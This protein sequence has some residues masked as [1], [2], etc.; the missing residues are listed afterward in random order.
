MLAKSQRNSYHPN[1]VAYLELPAEGLERGVDRCLGGVRRRRGG[2]APAARGDAALGLLA[3]DEEAEEVG[4]HL[5]GGE[6]GR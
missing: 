1:I 4:L 5:V 3:H 6:D 2:L